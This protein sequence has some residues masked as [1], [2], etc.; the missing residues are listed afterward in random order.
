M[1][2]DERDFYTN[3]EL[4][5]VINRFNKA[6]T[7]NKIEYFDVFECEGLADYFLD[8]DKLKSA[9]QVIQM[10]L[11]IH[12]DSVA[13]QIKNAQI[14]L[15]NGDPKQ[16]LATITLAESVEQTNPDVY[17]VKG[18]ALITLGRTTEAI[19][20]YQLS[21][22]Y[23][24]EEKDDLLYSIAVTLGQAGE[25]DHAIDFLNEAHQSNPQN[26]LVLYELG[27][28]HDKKQDFK[29][30][31]HFYNLYLDIDPFNASVWYNLGIAYNRLGNED[32]AIEAYDYAIVLQDDFEQAYYNKA[33]ALSN[34]N[35]YEKA[36]D[37][38][39]EYIKRDKHN[40]DAYCYLGECYL[41]L[42]RHQEA[43]M[44]Y[45]KATRLNKSNPNGW[46]G[47]GLIM[48]MEGKLTDA[49]VFLKKSIKLD[50]ANPDYW[51]IY[52]KI[53]TELENFQQAETAFEKATSLDPD[54]SDGWIS[55][56]EMEYEKGCLNDAIQILKNAL[57]IIE[58]DSGINYR[59]TA[60]LLEN[61][62]ELT[63]T[64]YLEKALE[65]DVDCYRDLFDYYPAAKQNESIRKVIKEHQSTKL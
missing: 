5:E 3:E 22:R 24:Y 18:S 1:D 38:Y 12:P 14:Q 57:T 16:C 29:T 40:D 41:N 65:I 61:N 26:E 32:K 23:N 2:E 7:E 39:K 55:F 50:D 47:A 15:L 9:E 54:N 64:N 45:R 13:L 11:S 25:T 31:I 28:Y 58:G 59:L 53:N 43:L 27:F 6:L 56:A 49:Q 21:I 52:G 37:C 63:A 20:A 30:C 17:L 35:Q 44:N 42:E 60:Y 10:G 8:E 46:Y 48:W 62:D 36:I 51:L 33:N 4:T 19:E 34:S